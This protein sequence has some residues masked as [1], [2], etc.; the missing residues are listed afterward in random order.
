MQFLNRL[1]QRRLAAIVLVV[2]IVIGGLVWLGSHHKQ[3]TSPLGASQYYDPNSHQTISD[4]PQKGPDSY[5]IA[6]N[7]PIFLGISDLL[8]YGVTDDQLSD[9][10]SAMNSYI[11]TVKAIKE[12][13]INVDS[14]KTV[15]NDPKYPND[16]QQVYF[17]VVL[18]RKTS[19][20]ASFECIDISQA[21]L[22][23]EDNS[24]KVVFNSGILNANQ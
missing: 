16:L 23:L 1:G 12:V 4:E 22:V 24:H 2:L 20:A 13:S 3:A 6:P 18:D 10:K 15:V 17:K 7:Q 8:K 9:F 5:G 11:Q 19:Y 14:I 21:R